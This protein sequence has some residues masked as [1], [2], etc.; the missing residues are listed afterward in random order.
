M[1][2]LIS[3]ANACRLAGDAD[4]AIG[5]FNQAMR[6]RPPTRLYSAAPK[7][8]HRASWGD[9]SDLSEAILLDPYSADVMVARAITYRALG[10]NAQALSDLGQAIHLDPLCWAAYYERGV[11]LRQLGGTT[12]R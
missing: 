4:A 6:L 1:A 9:L 3:R 5:D 8:G 10:D 7:P 11:T 2:A 12:R